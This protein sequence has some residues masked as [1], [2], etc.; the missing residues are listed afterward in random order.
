MG[1]D[2]SVYVG[3]YLKLERTQINESKTRRICSKCNTVYKNDA[4]FCSKDGSEI[5]EEQYSESVDIKSYRWLS[6]LYD[7][8]EDYPMCDAFYTPEYLHDNTHFVCKPNSSTKIGVRIDEN[9]GFKSIT[10]EL[11]EKSLTTFK[12]EYDKELEVF[13]SLGIKYEIEFGILGY[14][15]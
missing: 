11:I 4:K 12:S 5:V 1:S 15:S 7:E 10:P 3:P 13:D 14:W 9:G 8:L 6:D 2:Y